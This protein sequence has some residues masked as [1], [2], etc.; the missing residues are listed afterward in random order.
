[1]NH[2]LR[3]AGRAARLCLLMLLALTGISRLS[4]LESHAAVFAVTGTTHQDYPTGLQAQ[5]ILILLSLGSPATDASATSVAPLTNGAASRPHS[6]HSTEGSVSEPKQQ[7]VH[8]RVAGRPVRFVNNL[9]MSGR[10][11]A[12]DSLRQ[13]TASRPPARKLAPTPTVVSPT[14]QGTISILDQRTRQVI[15]PVLW[16][17]G[18]PVPLEDFRLL[19]VDHWGFDGSEHQGEVVIHKDVA[20]AVLQ[21]MRRLWEVRFPIERMEPVNT[22]TGPSAAVAANNTTALNCRSV[23]G[24]P[25]VWSE[26]SYGRAI[27]INP[28]RNP[29]VAA[30]GTVL[31]AE[32]VAYTDRSRRAVGML[33]AG[34]PA[35]EAFKDIGWHWGGDWTNPADYQH[36]SATGR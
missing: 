21:A 36:F 19:Q 13:A 35:V 16:R 25:G 30:N 34:D 15:T 10:R 23:R 7:R 31:P 14:F 5:P 27:D 26:H 32:G 18:C 28:V 29:Y 2:R 3:V 6:A 12:S 20:G 22:Y 1:M 24:V 11:L 17:P 8:S 33:R 4:P 9:V